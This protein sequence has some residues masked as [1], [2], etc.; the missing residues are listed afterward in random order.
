M[1]E[2]DYRRLASRLIATAHRAGRCILSHYGRAHIEYKDDLSPVTAA[3]READTVIVDALKRIAPGVAIVSEESSPSQDIEPDGRFFLVDPLDGTKEF[4]HQRE[5]FTVNIALIEA[6]AP[7]FGLVYAPAASKLYLT[8]APDQAVRA[9]L[10]AAQPV[11]DFAG[12]DLT[13]IATRTPPPEGLVAAVSRSH[14]DSRTQAFL[15]ENDI[16]ETR[17]SGSSLKF[18]VLA[19]GQADV[20]PRFGRTM[21]WDTAAGHAV[22]SAAGGSVLNEDGSPF[23][24]G[25]S[26][27][28]FA[29]P[30]FIAWG[31]AP[32]GQE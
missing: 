29:N 23:I 9:R 10:D 21:E 18:C 15:E 25:K 7:R 19:E 4:I 16:A 30:G 27:E 12:L 6:R 14:L 31:R 22:L 24:Y 1:T 8:L 26:Q 11:P 32:E 3:D 17:S 20:Y 28:N 5:E 13:P 2:T